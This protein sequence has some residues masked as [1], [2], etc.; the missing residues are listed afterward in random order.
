[1]L[2]ESINERLDDA[3]LYQDSTKLSKPLTEEIE[4]YTK[5]L[6]PTMKDLA[7]TVKALPSTITVYEGY[8]I[9]TIC[10]NRSHRSIP[11]A[12]T[13]GARRD[14]NCILEKISRTDKHY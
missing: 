10:L 12:T 6:E 7:S 13:H 9:T 5:G 4:S 1:M 2:Q 11:S 8:D 3:K 14:S